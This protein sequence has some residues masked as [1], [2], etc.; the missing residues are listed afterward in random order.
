MISEVFLL[1][2]TAFL[3][4]RADLIPNANFRIVFSVNESNA[5]VNY[6]D[7]SPSKFSGYPLDMDEH[8]LTTLISKNFTNGS[9]EWTV[10]LTS[11]VL[12]YLYSLKA[13]THHSQDPEIEFIIRYR[14]G[15]ILRDIFNC[16]YSVD[17][18]IGEFSIINNILDQNDFY[19]VVYW[20]IV[21][22]SK[23][24]L[25]TSLSEDLESFLHDC[26]DKH[27]EWLIILGC[28]FIATL[29]GLLSL[30]FWLYN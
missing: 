6:H 2:L 10:C 11:L 1:I 29:V 18:Y 17:D 7:L 12:D 21:K 28:V 23:M 3:L 19:K 25:N 20:K 27:I 15:D 13:T 5:V 30:M 16:R 4:I 14:Y 26:N 9:T 24:D 8:I 22:E